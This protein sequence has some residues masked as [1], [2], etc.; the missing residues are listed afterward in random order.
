MKRKIK[1]CTG[2][3]YINEL[4]YCRKYQCVMGK[5]EQTGWFI[6]CIDCRVDDGRSD[7]MVINVEIQQWVPSGFYCKNCLRKSYYDNGGAPGH[8]VYCELFKPFLEIDSKG[9]VLK[10]KSCLIAE[11]KEREKQ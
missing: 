10:C 5:D 7:E 4:G 6:P 11:L 8:R 1:V 2:C 9:N 3:K